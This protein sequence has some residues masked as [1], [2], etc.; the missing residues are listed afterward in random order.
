MH[1]PMTRKPLPINNLERL[2]A[3]R[4]WCHEPLGR[5]LAAAE[6]EVLSEALSNVF[7]YH[8][9]VLDPS[10]QPDSLGASRIM[11]QVVQTCTQDGLE[12]PPRLLGN[13]ESLP[14]QSDS[15]DAFLLPHVLELANNPHQ[16]LRE[17]DRCLVPE[18]HLV[19][20]GFNP[21]GWWGL[22]RL[23]FGWRSRAPWSLRFISLPRLKD[24]LSLLG[25]DTIQSRYLFPRPPWHYGAASS[26]GKILDRLHRDEWPLLAA[27]YLLVAR[28]R[29]A[30]LTP[31]KPRWRPR[32]SVLAGGVAETR[33]GNM[34]HDG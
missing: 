24:W 4:A 10:C 3:L 11:H 22:R 13:P 1:Q 34:P 32:R 31:V 30:T 7:G 14:L 8:L 12:H 19:V 16:S 28:K 33:Q 25:F 21:Y 27:S 6:Q 29:V 20:L 18:G 9:V 17:I 26:R 2:R 15:I 5:Q 23:L